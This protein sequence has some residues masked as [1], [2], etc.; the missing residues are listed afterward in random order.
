MT[1]FLRPYKELNYFSVATYDILEEQSLIE[2]TCATFFVPPVT[3]HLTQVTVLCS[4]SRL[5]NVRTKCL[6]VTDVYLIPGI[7]P[8]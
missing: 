1:D 4:A 7:S 3:P 5:R 8:S 2:V 6:R